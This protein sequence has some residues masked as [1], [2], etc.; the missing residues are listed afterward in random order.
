MNFISIK[1]LFNKKSEWTGY[2][3]WRAQVYSGNYKFNENARKLTGFG[4]YK[5]VTGLEFMRG[6]RDS[7]HQQPAAASPSSS[8]SVAADY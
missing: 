4:R 7:G 6:K 3:R 5:Y 1:L 2:S 8:A